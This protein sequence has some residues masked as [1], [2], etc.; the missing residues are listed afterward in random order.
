MQ[1]ALDGTDI[2]AVSIHILSQAPEGDYEGRVLRYNPGSGELTIAASQSREPFSVFVS[3]ST[4]FVRVGQPDF[5]SAQSGPADLTS[6]P[7]VSIKFETGNS[8]NGVA[9]QITILAVPGAAFVFSG[10][11]SG[12]DLSAGSIT[13]VDPH[14]DRSYQVFFDPRLFPESESLHLGSQIE[15]T[16]SYNGERY[17]VSKLTT[18]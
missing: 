13:M 10:V 14:D 2:F 8:G 18:R 16:A 3:R 15:V 17:E 11:I 9:S 4:S 6:G 5:A 7:L 1:T 12:L